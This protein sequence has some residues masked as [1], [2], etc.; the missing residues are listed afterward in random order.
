VKISEQTI[1]EFRKDRF[2]VCIGRDEAIWREK[3]PEKIHCLYQAGIPM[4]SSILAN[5][6]EYSVRNHILQ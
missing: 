6:V 3:L 1:V 4:R 5:A 2:P